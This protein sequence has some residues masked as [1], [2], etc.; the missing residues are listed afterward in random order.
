MYSPE[1]PF[2][3]RPQSAPVE[4][5]EGVRF[6]AR[7]LGTSGIQTLPNERSAAIRTLGL[8]DAERAAYIEVYLGM[9]LWPKE[10]V[11]QTDPDHRLLGYPRDLDSSALLRSESNSTG[12][13]DEWF[14]LIQSRR[15]SQRLS[16]FERGVT[17]GDCCCKWTATTTCPWT[18]PAAA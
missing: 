18:G 17:P 11:P 7:S 13:Y 6:S 1:D 5:N 12:H 16:E 9:D 3:F 14:R 15:P 10:G 2:T 8:S 4:I